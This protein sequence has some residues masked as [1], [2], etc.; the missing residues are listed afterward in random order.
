MVSFH[1]AL[2]ESPSTAEFEA[3]SKKRKWE[4]P[5]ADEFFKVITGPETKKSIFD[6]TSDKWLQY[7]SIQVYIKYIVK[8]SGF[9]KTMISLNT[10]EDPWKSPASPSPAQMSLD[11]ELNLTCDQSH[12]KI[13]PANYNINEKQ[14]SS[15]PGS[16]IY[17]SESSKV[18]EDSGDLS[19]SSSS[20]LSLEGDHEE[21]VTT[22]CMRC[23][24]LVMLCKSSPACPNCKFMHSPDQNPSTFLKRK[25]SLLC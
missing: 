18:K 23:H 24:M 13:K 11:L 4:E 15:S 2:P 9:C 19:R 16:G 17:G 6:I 7:P 1:K 25:C 22:V 14:N 8:L 20:W 5:L 3:S 10:S 21:M 12:R